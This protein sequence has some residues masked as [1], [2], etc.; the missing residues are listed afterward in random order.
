MP[1]PLP[2]ELDDEVEPDEEPPEDEADA[3]C[4]AASAAFSAAALAAAA[5]LASRS[6]ISVLRPPAVL[7]SWAC[8]ASTWSL[9]SS[10]CAT[11]LAADLRS[12]SSATRRSEISWR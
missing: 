8:S 5:A 10:R 4:E 7:S 1:P 12:A 3:V 9:L 2:P 6:A 11:S